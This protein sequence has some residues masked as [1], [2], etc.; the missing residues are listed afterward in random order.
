[1]ER[2][3]A[4]TE[5]DGNLLLLKGA[6]TLAEANN[7]AMMNDGMSGATHIMFDKQK[8]SAGLPRLKMT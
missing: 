3:R 2:Q 1:M 8:L 6:S 7:I 4:I 5:S